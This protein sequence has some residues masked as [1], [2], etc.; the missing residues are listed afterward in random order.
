VEKGYI[1]REGH[2]RLLAELQHLRSVA[3]PRMVDEV[4]AAAA[5]G[6]RSENAEY[7]YGK[8]R[9]REIDRRTRWLEK[10]L[11]ALE[12]VDADAPRATGKV[13]FGA[14]VTVADEEGEERTF[15]VLGQDEVDLDRG[16]ISYISPLGRG[17]LGK[18]EGD[19]I[20][21]KS[22][23]GDREFTVLRVQYGQIFSA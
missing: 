7:I 18:C 17:L 19:T 3:R 2:A 14:W 23:S 9:L 16:A 22:P 10:R 6:D 1:S 8:K 21:V 15:R 12:V 11:D 13:H 4:A 20:T 5:Q